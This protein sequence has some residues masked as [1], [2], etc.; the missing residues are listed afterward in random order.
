MRW[1][2]YAMHGAAAALA[3]L[4]CTTLLAQG[5]SSFPSKPVTIIVPFPPGAN[6]DNEAR[7][8]Q[9]GLSVQLKQ[10]VVIDNKGGASGILA[11]SFVAKAAP[12]GHTLLFTNTTATVLP[13]VRK[14]L[15][16]DLLRDFAPVIM[17]TKNIFV[18]LIRPSFPGNTFAEFIA[19]AREK[20]GIVTWSTT[21]PG[22]ALHMTGEW[23]SQVTG[24]K[25]T[26]VH[27]KGGNQ[28]E[29][30]LLAGR[31]DAVPKN[32]SASLLLIK[33]RKVKVV[34]VLA[35]E[36]TPALPG[37]KA[38]AEMGYPDYAHSAW[39]GLIAPAATPAAIVNK[40]HA[41][42][43]KAITTPKAMARWEAQGSVVVGAT[44]EDFRKSLVMELALWDKLVRVNNIKID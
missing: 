35:A 29:I 11:N 40:L 41:E 18:L 3:A 39:I 32:L 5:A 44:P 1:Q 14:D 7:V 10:P 16:Y 20:P 33:S 34:A 28:A 30:D 15:P 12:D 9:E 22:S 27:Y 36:Q 31:I 6:A 25:F 24:A 13:A 17:T 42:V 38:V 2:K 21:G 26:F 37:V 8:Y 23:L 43:L 19:Y 4:F